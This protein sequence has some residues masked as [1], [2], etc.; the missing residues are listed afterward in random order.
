MAGQSVHILALWSMDGNISFLVLARQSHIPSRFRRVGI[1]KMYPFATVAGK[2]KRFTVEELLEKG[3]K[4]D[5][6][7]V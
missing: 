6:V 2:A 7:I 5:F 4:G 3:H 1:V